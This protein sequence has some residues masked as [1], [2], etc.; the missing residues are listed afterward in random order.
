MGVERML[1]SCKHVFKLDPAKDIS[2]AHLEAICE[3][4][5]DLIMISGTDNVTEFNVLQLLS[6]VRRYFVPVALEISHIDAVVP[7][8]DHYFVPVVINTTNI[9]YRD[10]LMLEALKQYD[11][12]IDFNEITVLPYLIFN[13]ECKAF[14]QAECTEILDTDI[15]YYVQLIDK[16]YR[17][18][19]LYI[20]FSGTLASMDT[21]S[22]I[23]RANDNCHILYGGGIVDKETFESCAPFADTLVVG[24]GI[25]DDINAALNTVK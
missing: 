9:K 22:I 10:G 2:D 20:E 21:L 23:Q 19:Y 17:Q 3:S 8:F 16:M 6:R 25:Y 1:E 11:Y 12:T 15:K 13:P 4:G 18:S 24:N 5:T 7:G 14:T